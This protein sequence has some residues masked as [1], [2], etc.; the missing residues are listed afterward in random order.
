M[1]Q[2]HFGQLLKKLEAL[3]HYFYV[4]SSSNC[5]MDKQEAF[6]KPIGFFPITVNSEIL[7]IIAVDHETHKGQDENWSPKGKQDLIW[8]S[9]DMHYRQSHIQLRGYMILQ[10]CP[11]VVNGL[12]GR[13]VY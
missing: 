7:F 8:L 11:I 10:G 9:Y 13:Q 2:F 6:P 1:F 12:T 5:N 3:S 4:R